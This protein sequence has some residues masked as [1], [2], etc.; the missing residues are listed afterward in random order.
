MYTI[1]AQSNWD[2]IS[3]ILLEWAL[4]LAY[5][6]IIFFVGKWIASFTKKSL[7][8]VCEAKELDKSLTSFCTNVLYYLLMAVVLVAAL[9]KLGVP[10]T[11]VIAIMGAA[12]LAVGLALQ[13]SLSNF[14]AGVMILMFRPFKIGD[15]IVGGGTMGVVK[16]ID[17]LTTVLNSFDGKKVIVPNGKFLQ[18]SI[19]NISANPT[20][21]VD[22][23]YSIAYTDDLDQAKKI[24]MDILVEDERVLK[25]PAPAVALSELADNSVDIVARAWVDSPNWWPV[26]CETQEKVKKAFDSSGLTI[27][28]PQRDVHI[29]QEE[30]VS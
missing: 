12:G 18:D 29:F 10:T 6:L 1:V 5:A 11:S 17:L 9:S 15:A 16:E 22:M 2:T 13:S 20:R 24:I 30:K 27:P 4:R 3:I 28:F 21:R 25:D 26:L 8:K 14:A 7:R 19:T 23:T